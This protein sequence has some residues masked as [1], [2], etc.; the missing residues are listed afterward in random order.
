MAKWIYWRP[1]LVREGIVKQGQPLPVTPEPASLAPL[2]KPV[3]VEL[4]NPYGKLCEY[5]GK[6]LQTKQQKKYCCIDCR[7]KANER[8]AAQLR[9]AQ[10]KTVTRIC[11]F[12]GEEYHPGVGGRLKYCSDKCYSLAQRDYARIRA[13]IRRGETPAEE[14]DRR[15]L[16]CGVKLPAT[17]HHA[18]TTCSPECR[19]KFK[20]LYSRERYRRKKE[21]QDGKTPD[22][23]TI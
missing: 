8:I 22:N 21:A 3:E 2:S 16:V 15:C 20:C 4:P 23:R 1:D 9:H 7:N 6:P 10:A 5:C 13:M 18:Q 12:C 17:L 19:Q 11:K 14:E